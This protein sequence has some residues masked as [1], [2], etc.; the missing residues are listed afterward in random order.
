MA[1]KLRKV[2]AVIGSEGK[3]GSNS[4]AVVGWDL[5]SINATWFV[6][7][8]TIAATTPV[9]EWVVLG[10]K[11]FAS[12]NETVAQATL[13]YAVK[14]DEMRVELPT[15]TDLTQAHIN[16]KFD[17]NASQQVVLTAAWTQVQLVEIVSTRVG[18][19]KLL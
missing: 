11:T 4:L 7:K 2:W 16:D 19:F 13:D 15:V 10:E 18:S 5:V 17:I 1:G 8:S 9:I 12:D 3:I 14:S 6:A